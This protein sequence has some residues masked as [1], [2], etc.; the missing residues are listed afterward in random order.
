M[1][2][3]AGAGPQDV[4]AW[5]PI[6][7]I[8]DF[9]DIDVVMFA[10]DGKFVCKCNIGVSECVF[11]E[12]DHFSRARSRRHACSTYKAFVEPLRV[13]V[14]EGVTPPIQ[15][16]LLTSSVSIRPGKTRSGQ[17]ATET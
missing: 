8:D 15:R 6:G 7:E 2:A 3:Y 5:M 4:D 1:A 9:P 16:S 11:R 14:H 12:L 17:Y 13:P 10:N